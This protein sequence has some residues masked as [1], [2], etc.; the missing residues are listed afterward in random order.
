LALE[1]R[2]VAVD[3]T[4]EYTLVGVY[5]F[6]KGLF[7]H[8]PK[9][10]AELGAYRFFAVAAGDLVL[11]N[12]GAWE[13]GIGYA[14]DADNG[15]IGNH[16]VLTYTPRDRRIDANWVRWYLVSERGMTLIR[17]AA[18]GTV[19][20]NRTLA[21][22]RFEA[23][24]IPLPPIDEQ[25]RV[26]DRLDRLEIVAAET[27]R[28]TKRAST[29]SDALAVSIAS[30]PDVADEAKT[31]SGWRRAQLSSAMQPANERVAVE[32]SQSYPNVGVY[33]F[34]RG[35]FE[36]PEIDGATT[37]A[38]SLNRVKAGQ[39]MYSRLFA[40]EGAYTYV[41]PKFDGYY[42]SNEFP[43]FD[44]DPE[45][46]DARWVAAFLRSPDRWAELGGRSKGLGVRRQRVPVEAVM[47]YEIWLPPIATQRAMVAAIEEVEKAGSARHAVNDRI[48]ALV[49]AALNE[50]FAS[51][52]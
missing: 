35:L 48:D 12:I 30:R 45:Q 26:A 33:S 25:R 18:P 46:L 13:G 36:K 16:R 41:P 49:P 31:A 51:L 43:A 32:A 27:R 15:V 5:S 39:F 29:L 1:R 42:V 34:G 10:G 40:F 50:G 28:A 7:H 14:T 47:E 11:S 19:M 17:G 23:L 44:V 22:D 24:E 37:R 4:A 2:E 52:S 38:S 8:E 6:G 21:M 9:L 20:R 3:P